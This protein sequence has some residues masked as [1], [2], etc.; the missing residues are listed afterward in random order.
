M[1]SFNVLDGHGI[2]LLK[3]AS[4]ETAIISARNTPIVLKRAADL[5]IDHVIQ[6]ASD[7]RAALESLLE[8]TGFDA[9]QCGYIGR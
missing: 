3:H 5:D 4:V 9:E 7:K 2:K 6:G 8:K 1:K